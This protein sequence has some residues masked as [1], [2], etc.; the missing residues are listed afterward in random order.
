MKIVGF[1]LFAALLSMLLGIAVGVCFP[2]PKPPTDD[3]AE[4]VPLEQSTLRSPIGGWHDGKFYATVDSLSQ[5]RKA[6]PYR[7]KA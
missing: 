3:P 6:A 7:V 5:F 1:I 2:Q 4:Q